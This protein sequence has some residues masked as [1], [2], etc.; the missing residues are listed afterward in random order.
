MGR[1]RS[2]E[3]LQSF[4]NEIKLWLVITCPKYTVPSWRTNIRPIL[5]WRKYRQYVFLGQTWGLLYF[6][7]VRPHQHSAHIGRTAGAKGITNIL[8]Q[9]FNLRKALV[10]AWA[11]CKYY[12]VRTKCDSR[13]APSKSITLFFIIHARQRLFCCRKH[14]DRHDFVYAR[15]G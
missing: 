4:S 1:N 8:K 11:D 15:A 12:Y 13:S 7:L 3:D 5:K 6:N 10:S 14:S 2:I 9:H